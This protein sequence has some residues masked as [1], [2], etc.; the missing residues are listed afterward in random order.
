VLSPLGTPPKINKK[1]AATRPESLDGKTVY[2]V[3]CRFDD[4]IELLK[5]VAGWFAANMPSVKTKIVSLSATYQ[6]DDPKTW[7]EI[8]TNGHAAIIGVGHCSNCAPAVTT[9]A[10]TLETQYGVP[11]VALHTDK[12]DKVV[13]SVAK[14]AGLPEAPRSFVPQPVMGKTAQ[15]LAAYVNGNDPITG[16]PV[17][18]EVVMALTTALDSAHAGH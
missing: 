13:A 16:R 10:I 12:F 15:E 9:H 7:N 11:T 18:Q 3:D 17:M 5:Q 1:Q 8:K 2:L 14:M 6:K 4:S